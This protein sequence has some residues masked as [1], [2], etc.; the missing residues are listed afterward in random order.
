M[1]WKLNFSPALPNVSTSFLL[2]AVLCFGFAFWNVEQCQ[3]QVSAGTIVDL[4]TTGS[5]GSPEVSSALSAQLVEYERQLNALLLTRRTEEKEFVGKVVDQ[6]RVGAIP[7]KLVTTSFEWV[8][9]KRPGT[10]Y[11]FVYFEKVLRLQATRI[12]LGSEIPPFDFS[13]FSQETLP[14]ATAPDIGTTDTQSNDGLG[15]TGL[16]SI[17][18]FSSSFIDRIRREAFGVD[19]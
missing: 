15:S 1:S 19:R 6:I 13:I 4:T 5:S 12:G 7:S 11:P 2:A 16:G 8:R 17:F 18:K 10:K 9:N 3:G 14:F